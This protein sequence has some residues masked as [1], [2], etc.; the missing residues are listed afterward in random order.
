MNRQAFVAHLQIDVEVLEVWLAQ[1]WLVPSDGV[2][3][4][5]S[6]A[7]IARAKLIGEL[8]GGLGVNDP[9]I[10]VI[11]HLLDQLHGFRRAFEGLHQNLREP[12]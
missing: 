2:E 12:R 10:D 4:Q 11:L 7:D 3:P 8:K 1:G 5:F 9:G 6:D